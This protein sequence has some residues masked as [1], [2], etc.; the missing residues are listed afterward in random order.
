MSHN[1]KLYGIMLGDVMYDDFI[2]CLKI[3][4]CPELI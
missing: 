2:Q 1:M 4:M 3:A